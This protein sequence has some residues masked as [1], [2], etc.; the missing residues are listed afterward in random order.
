MAV[1]AFLH[2]IGICKIPTM[3]FY[4]YLFYCLLIS[5]LCADNQIVE[6]ILLKT[7]HRMD[8]I[9]YSF[10]VDSK[11]SGKKKK[12]KYFAI[13]IHWPSGDNLLCQTRVTSILSKQKKPSS[14]W[15]HRFHD[16]SKT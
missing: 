15:E 8:G 13:S 9:D 14:F 16:G 10:K 7:I 1:L 2:S 6:D 11:I 12:E 5:I 4:L 3:K